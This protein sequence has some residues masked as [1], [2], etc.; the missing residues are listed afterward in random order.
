M[1][2][3]TREKQKGI[4]FSTLL[5]LTLFLYTPLVGQKKSQEKYTDA[6]DT[7]PSKQRYNV[8]ITKLQLGR[9]FYAKTKEGGV[10]KY[11]LLGV[12]VPTLGAVRSLLNQMSLSKALRKEMYKVSK[13]LQH[14]LRK[15]IRSKGVVSLQSYRQQDFAGRNLV[16]L[17]LPNQKNINLELLRQGYAYPEWSELGNKQIYAQTKSKFKKAF[18]IALKKRRGLWRLWKSH[19]KQEQDLKKARLSYQNQKKIQLMTYNVENLFDT[20]DSDD[21]N[22]STFLPLSAKQSNSHKKVCAKVRGRYRKKVC[23]KLDWNSKRLDVKMQ[24]LAK[25]ISNTRKGEKAKRGPDV[26][27]LQ[28][29]ENY[30]ILKQFRDNYLGFGKYRIVHFESRDRRGIDVALL[31]RLAPAAL[32]RYY[33]IDFNRFTRTRGIL[34]AP[35]YLPNKQVLHTF[36]FHFPSQGAPTAMRKQALIY[37]SLL[38]KSLAKGSLVVAAGDCN[39]TKPEEKKLYPNYII[40][41]W[42]VSHYLGCKSCKGT[43]Y[44]PPRKSW[45]F[46]DVFYSSLNLKKS[47]ARWQILPSSI[48]IANTL[49]FQNKKGKIP[50]AYRFGNF[51]GVSDHWPMIMELK[52][53]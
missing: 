44:Y 21:T 45:S 7:S 40:P 4:Y 27:F 42:N 8:K 22:D 52:R 19:Q 41:Y 49:P 50:Q 13:D 51:N 11:A 37:L 6:D 36:V 33:E 31:T 29:I 48:R 14:Y 16:E 25:V 2:K 28:E 46:F 10:K 1:K 24:R 9:Y 39:I 34:H 23:Y 15:N 20:I 17:F 35:L 38:K 12:Y 18:Q 47:K 3:L 53:R 32:P 30:S 5:L 43:T 26:L